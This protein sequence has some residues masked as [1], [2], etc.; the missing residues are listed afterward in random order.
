MSHELRSITDKELSEI[1]HKHLLWLRNQPGGERGD[2]SHCDLSM[3]NFS[4]APLLV[5]T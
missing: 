2:L 5:L 1:L 3:R 4:F